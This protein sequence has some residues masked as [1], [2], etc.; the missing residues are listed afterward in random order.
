MQ[1]FVC[2]ALL[3]LLVES[4]EALTASV[5]SIFFHIK[6]TWFY[7]IC[8]I[9]SR[10][11]RSHLGCRRIRNCEKLRIEKR[12]CIGRK[13]WIICQSVFVFLFFFCGTLQVKLCSGVPSCVVLRYMTHCDDFKHFSRQEI[14]FLFVSHVLGEYSGA[15]CSFFYTGDI[16]TM[17]F[18]TI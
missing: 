1:H 3:L 7:T 2:S 14:K 9:I 18:P 16:N 4:D 8:Q 10:T 13:I 6:A 15:C 5:L 17:G 12:F 11:F